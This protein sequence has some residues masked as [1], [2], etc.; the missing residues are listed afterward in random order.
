M[1]S[2]AV[3]LFIIVVVVLGT[4]AAG[5]FFR[6]SNRVVPLEELDRSS[7]YEIRNSDTSDEFADI[8]K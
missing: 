3:I 8:V 2:L 6:K 4:A 1:D 7:L 5:I